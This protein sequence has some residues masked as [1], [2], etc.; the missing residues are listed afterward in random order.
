[1]ILNTEHSISMMITI[2]NDLKR[3]YLMSESIHFTY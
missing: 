3:Y 1:M 2:Y